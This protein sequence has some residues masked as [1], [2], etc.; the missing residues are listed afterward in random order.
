MF[1]LIAVIVFWSAYGLTRCAQGE[2]GRRDAW[3]ICQPGDYI[4]A[5]SAPRKTGIVI[6]CLDPGDKVQTDGEMRN[7]FLHIYGGFEQ[8]DAWVSTMYITEEEPEELNREYMIVSEGRVACR[9]GI[10]GK[11]RA[12]AKEG[13]LVKVYWW[14][15]T[16]CV[17][18][19]GFIMSEYV[20][21]GR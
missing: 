7:G 13:D 14:T 11:R 5:R 1:F 2:S 6:G 15:E 21:T 19:R 4:N 20:D 3:I 17:T 12:W 8:E 10:D 18:S 16:W 9:R